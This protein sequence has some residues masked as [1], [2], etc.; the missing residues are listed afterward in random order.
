MG[1]FHS[2]Q[3]IVLEDFN[4]FKK[5]ETEIEDIKDEDNQVLVEM[6]FSGLTHFDYLL[7]KGS[8][9][10]FPFFRTKFPYYFGLNGSGKII[11]VGK[12]VKEYKEGDIIF[13]VNRNGGT[14]S[15]YQIFHKD[16]IEL[17]PSNLTIEESSVIGINGLCA[18]QTIKQSEIEKGDRILIIGA[19]GNIGE[20]LIQLSKLKGG[21]VIGISNKE[22]LNNLKELGC[23]QV[24]DETLFDYELDIDNIDII[25]DLKG[26]ELDSIKILNK[27][28]KYFKIGHPKELKYKDWLK[29][30]MRQMK[31]QFMNLFSS[32][33]YY[34]QTTNIKK[35]NLKELHDLI[36]NGKLKFKK[37]K[38]IYN[39]NQIDLA[40]KSIENRMNGYHIV[41][42]K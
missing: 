35:E 3:R 2:N 10:F 32:K 39:M 19:G 23:D 15:E 26:N 20:M 14:I 9:N 29:I 36:E 8:F 28:G 12:N 6:Y 40:L 17:K 7:F 41:K 11:K 42:I 25:Y 37:K 16:D 18:I 13:G 38:Y 30:G 22:N 4:S 34:F 1:L 24:L 5:I 33:K 31:N 27:K 21:K